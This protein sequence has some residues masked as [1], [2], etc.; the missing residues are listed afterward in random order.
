[1]GISVIKAKPQKIQQYVVLGGTFDP[2]HN[3]HLIT[4]N[5]LADKLGYDCVYL[6]PCGDAYHKQGS[7]SAGHRLAMLELALQQ[8]PKL[9]VDDQELKRLGATYTVDT[10]TNIR[11]K[12]G[13]SAHLVW[14]MGSDA[15]QSL[16]NWHNWQTLFSLANVLIVAR[17]NELPADLSDWPAKC[18]TDI[19]EFKKQSNGCYLLTALPP[20]AVSSTQIRLQVVN[21]ETVGNHVPQSVIDYIELHGLY[22]GE[23]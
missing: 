9:K 11:Q 8:E 6:M 10:L 4:A 7:S 22:R 5:A 2:V 17:N 18:F 19:N 21:Q 16:T 15:A 23:N 13:P 20:V 14:V 12:I 1:M 3:G